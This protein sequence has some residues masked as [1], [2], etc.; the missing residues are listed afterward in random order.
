M[1]ENIPYIP[2]REPKPREKGITMM[3]DKG[4]SVRQAEDFVSSSAEFTDVVKFGFGTAMI[5]RDLEKKIEIYKEANL[6]PYFGGTLFELY[7]VRGMF[8]DYRKLLNKYQI[9]MAEVSDGSMIIPHTEKLSYIEKLSR[10]V[11]V[12]S[13]VGSKQADVVFP[14]NVWVAMMKAEI[15]AGSW[16]VIAE[17]R[18]SGTVGIYNPDG[19]AN[20]PL[21]DDIVKQVQIENVLW[22]APIKSQQAWFIKLLGANVNLGNISPEEVVALE[23]LRLGL[24]GD[25]FSQFLPEDLK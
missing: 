10:E 4:L 7:I 18:E 19:S 6:I 21:I 13:E 5:T 24:R 3:M 9:P 25:T 22:E 1:I 8:D 20:I 12:L 23:T 11:T 14:P 16:K 2:E 17:A 15:E